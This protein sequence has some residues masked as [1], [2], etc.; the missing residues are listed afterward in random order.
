M[1]RSYNQVPVTAL[2]GYG[3]LQKENPSEAAAFE[4]EFEA[5]ASVLLQQHA[6]KQAAQ[7]PTELGQDVLVDGPDVLQSFDDNVVYSVLGAAKDESRLSQTAKARAT[8]ELEKLRVQTDDLMSNLR[9]EAAQRNAMDSKAVEII[10]L[11]DET[12]YDRQDEELARTAGELLQRVA[13][14][15]STKFRESTFLTLMAQLRDREVYVDGN[16]FVPKDVSFL[17]LPF[18]TQY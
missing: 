4:Q 11:E 15:T 14:D 2:H 7:T 8:E 18:P 5:H 3:S 10:D 1:Q 12:E 13:D 16:D 6:E 9:E 17:P